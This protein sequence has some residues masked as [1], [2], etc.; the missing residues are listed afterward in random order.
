MSFTY[1]SPEELVEQYRCG[2]ER[3]SVKALHDAEERRRQQVM[4]RRIGSQVRR[5]DVAIT[6]CMSQLRGLK[7][8]TVHYLDVLNS[9]TAAIADLEAK[10]HLLSLRSKS[11]KNQLYSDPPRS[12]ARRPYSSSFVT[13]RDKLRSNMTHDWRMR[14]CVGF[15]PHSPP[16][17]SKYSLSWKEAH[18]SGQLAQMTCEDSFYDSPSEECEARMCA[19]AGNLTHD[20]TASIRPSRHRRLRASATRPHPNSRL[21]DPVAFD[22][23]DYLRR[24]TSALPPI[25]DPVS[26]HAAHAEEENAASRTSLYSGTLHL[27]E[28]PSSKPSPKDPRQLRKNLLTVIDKYRSGCTYSL[29]SLFPPLD[30]LYQLFADAQPALSAI[31]S[32]IMIGVTLFK[33]AE[34]V[35]ELLNSSPFYTFVLAL[36]PVDLPRLPASLA[37]ARSILEGD[38]APSCGDSNIYNTVN[39]MVS[40]RMYVRAHWFDS[41]QSSYGNFLHRYYLKFLQINSMSRVTVPLWPQYKR[42]RLFNA[43]KHLLRDGELDFSFL[44]AILSTFAILHE[45]RILPVQR[46]TYGY[47]ELEICGHAI[48]HGT[49]SQPSGGA[50]RYT[51]I[52]PAWVDRYNNTYIESRFRKHRPAQFS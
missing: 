36:E 21:F 6:A 41:V 37:E 26:L 23:F 35:R 27:N 12:S 1:L 14:E 29:I 47:H 13:D 22:E 45:L 46:A 16:S 9:T 10:I 8:Q 31:K 17:Q 19:L 43:E 49:I 32:S 18:S 7:L 40:L 30:K 34:F 5:D 39:L 20:S 11:I 4:W 2:T 15:V 25:N 33:V 24:Q 48:E 50:T 38:G 42:V 44:Y 3:G 51:C 52:W 28:T